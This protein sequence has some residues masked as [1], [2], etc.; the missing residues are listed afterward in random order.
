MSKI[1]LN[2]RRR[3][4][5]GHAGRVHDWLVKY[6]GIEN[7]FMDVKGLEAGDIF[8]EKIIK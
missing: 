8:D 7:V 2:Y 4:S 6:F 3:D 5:S 1:F